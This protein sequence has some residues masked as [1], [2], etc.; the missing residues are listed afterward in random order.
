MKYEYNYE[1]QG[2]GMLVGGVIGVIVGLL[3]GFGIWG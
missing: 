2:I 3:I 1:A